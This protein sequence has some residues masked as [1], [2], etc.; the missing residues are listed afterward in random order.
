MTPAE[1]ERLRQVS[2][3][4]QLAAG[5]RHPVRTAMAVGRF[6]DAAKWPIRVSAAKIVNDSVVTHGGASD[7]EAT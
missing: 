5:M 6:E 1:S 2:Y 3:H 4:N 7:E